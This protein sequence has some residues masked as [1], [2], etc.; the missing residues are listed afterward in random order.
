MNGRRLSSGR[1]EKIPGSRPLHLGNYSGL[2]RPEHLIVLNHRVEDL[3]KTVAA[4]LFYTA[5]SSPATAKRL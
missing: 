5:S 1:F 3:P 4:I 2:Y